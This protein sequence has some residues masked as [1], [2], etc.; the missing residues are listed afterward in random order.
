[1][2][3][4]YALALALALQCCRRNL[5]QAEKLECIQA[6]PLPFAGPVSLKAPEISVVVMLDYS[7]SPLSASASGSGSPGVS[8]QAGGGRKERVEKGEC[9]GFR[10]A[11][12]GLLLG[13]GGMREV[14]ETAPHG[15]A[16]HITAHLCN[17]E[18]SLTSSHLCP[19]P[20]SPSFMSQELKKY[21]LKKR[22]YLGPTSLDPLLALLMATV[23]RVRP[24]HMVLDPFVGT[25]SILVRP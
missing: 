18:L 21:D 23:S 15:T 16:Q 5:T 8:V 3:D 10:Q 1:M 9:L 11:F 12:C 7:C 2:T 24:G 6:F 22:F 17:D 4:G 25:A 19:A 20:T 13:R 14:G